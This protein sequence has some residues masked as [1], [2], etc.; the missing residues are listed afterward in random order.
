[1]SPLSTPAGALRAG[2][3]LNSVTL[4]SLDGS[5]EAEFVPE[6]NLVCSS[7]RYLGAEYLH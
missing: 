7:L 5:T 4:H 2:E 1:M 6:A 3:R